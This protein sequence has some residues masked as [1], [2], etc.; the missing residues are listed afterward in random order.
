MIKP[1]SGDIKYY[2]TVTEDEL[3]ELVWNST[4]LIECFGLDRRIGNYKGKRPIGLYRWDIE[5]LYEI[6]SSILEEDSD[7]YYSDKESP[8]YKAMLSLVTKFKE[9]Y[10]I[11]FDK[12]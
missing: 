7:N 11:A 4:N 10:D 3:D 9:M 8:Q 1:G 2:L 5:A 12:Y 6:Y